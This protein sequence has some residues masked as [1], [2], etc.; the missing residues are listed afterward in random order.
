MEGLNLANGYWN[1]K[2][3]MKSKTLDEGSVGSGN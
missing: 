1:A 2:G 3:G